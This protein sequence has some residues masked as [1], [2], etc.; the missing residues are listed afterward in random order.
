MDTSYYIT[1][2]I[3]SQYNGNLI[4]YPVVFILKKYSL[5]T[6]DYI[7]YNKELMGVSSMFKEWSTFVE[8]FAYLIK[9]L[10]DYRHLE[11]FMTDFFLY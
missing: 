3:F 10:M 6:Y 11:Y 9:V 8:G 1:R 7:I 2:G 4:F 5:V